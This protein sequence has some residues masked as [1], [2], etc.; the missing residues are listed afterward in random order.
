MA[1][2]RLTRQQKNRIRLRQMQEVDEQRAPSDD[3]SAAA[4]GPRLKGIVT[5]NFGQQLEVEVQ[6][7]PQQSA[8]Y[9]C[10]QRSNLPP[11]VC[12]DR[13]IFASSP[14]DSGVIVGLEERHSEFSRPTAS[15][16]LKSVAANV[17]LVLIVLA[18]RP[19]PFLNLLDRYLVAVASLHLEPL[20]IINKSDLLEGEE[21][22]ALDTVISDYPT[23]GYPVYRVSAQLGSGLDALKA[24]LAGKTAVMVGQSGVG[25]SSLVNALGPDLEV[26]V[27]ELSGPADKGTHTTT[28]ARMFHLDGFDLI[29][30][31]G[32][33]EFG[34]WHVTPTELLE[35]FVEFRPFLG[36]CRFRDCSHRNE[37]GCA[38]QEA[39]ASGAVPAYRLD[40]Y[41]Q[42]LDSL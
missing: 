2:R 23:L 13:V 36:H 42:I 35:G 30:S 4:D 16:Q 8:L 28:A 17:D 33:R 40:S 12:G 31:P 41:F 27:G 3:S 18:P 19:Q 6:E 9:R 38:L 11:L 37:P 25:K 10:F 1:K 22:P 5:C 39:V 34:L 29:D 21:N 32:I 24:A 14:D 7:G 20:I 26:P 15:G